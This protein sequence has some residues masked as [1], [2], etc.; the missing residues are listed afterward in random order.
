M[1]SQGRQVW[2]PTLGPIA[3]TGEGLVFYSEMEA[4]WKRKESRL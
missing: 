2:T 4:T 3:C 1:G